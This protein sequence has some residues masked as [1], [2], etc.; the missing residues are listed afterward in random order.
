MATLTGACGRQA[1]LIQH[2]WKGDLLLSR[3]LEILGISTPCFVLHF[4][5]C[6]MRLLCGEGGK[7]AQRGLQRL[8]GGG[9]AGGGCAKLPECL[10]NL[11][12][13]VLFG[14]FWDWCTQG[15]SVCLPVC[16]SPRLVFQPL[17]LLLYENS[18]LWLTSVLCV[19]SSLLRQV[20]ERLKK[21]V[22]EMKEKFPGFTPG[23]AILQVLFSL[24]T[25]TENLCCFAV[26]SGQLM[27]I[28]K[29]AL[30]NG[31]IL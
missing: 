7:K 31:N 18:D 14:D 9:G 29:T 11:Q 25:T 20:R 13:S 12:T 24:M 27:S 3:E 16:P 15:L 1:D 10:S 23:L 19:F 4:P 2:V 17:V 5:L 28:T 6:P 21:Q 26:I 22:A 30:Q 8:G